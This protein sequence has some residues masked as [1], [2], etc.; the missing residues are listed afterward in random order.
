M[1]ANT[2]SLFSF[3]KFDLGLRHQRSIGSLLQV[4]GFFHG[5]S[6]Y[7]DNSEKKNELADC[8]EKQRESFVRK[9]QKSITQKKRKNKL[10]PSAMQYASV[11]IQLYLIIKNISLQQHIIPPI[12][13]MKNINFSRGKKTTEQLSPKHIIS[14]TFRD[15]V[16]TPPSP[17][18]DWN[19]NQ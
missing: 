6:K 19:K 13:L 7:H 10:I 8:H 17:T 15:T 16:R 5:I 9:K 3:I 18:P 4:D 2:A 1:E 14:A 12:H 11:I